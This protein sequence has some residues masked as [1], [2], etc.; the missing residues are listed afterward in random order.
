M[1]ESYRT[2]LEITAKD[3]IN[4]IMDVSTV[5]V[6][7]THLDVYKRQVQPRVEIP[8]FFCGFCRK[9]H[10]QRPPLVFFG[11]L[12]YTIPVSYTHL[13]VYKRQSIGRR[14]ASA[15]TPHSPPLPQ[16]MLGPLKY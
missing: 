3:R 5:P 10:R 6:S 15:H 9:L 4:I 11:Q 8:T 2:T 12:C 16:E 1:R 13:D 14:F 7:Y